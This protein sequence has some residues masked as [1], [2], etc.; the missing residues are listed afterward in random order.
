MRDGGALVLAGDIMTS[1]PGVKGVE[2]HTVGHGAIPRPLAL[3]L[4]PSG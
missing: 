4:V 3:R 1:V 2:D